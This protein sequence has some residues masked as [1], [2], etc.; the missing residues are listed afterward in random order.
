MSEYTYSEGEGRCPYCAGPSTLVTVQWKNGPHEWSE[1]CT[2][3]TL[4]S[5]R[6]RP[7]AFAVI[8]LIEDRIP[9]SLRNLLVRSASRPDSGVD[10]LATA[11]DAELLT[12]RGFGKANLAAFRKVWPVP[13]RIEDPWR[14]YAEMVAGVR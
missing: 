5:N 7:R 3:C 9:V 12:M 13:S 4:R 1:A 11:T 8:N 14:D 10:D 6:R 2:S